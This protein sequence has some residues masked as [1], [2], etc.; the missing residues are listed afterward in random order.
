MVLQKFGDSLDTDVVET[1][2]RELIRDII[3]ERTVSFH[4]SQ[5]TD[6]MAKLENDYDNLLEGEYS[7]LLRFNKSGVADIVFTNSNPEH[8]WNL[9]KFDA[10]RMSLID[11]PSGKAG[12]MDVIVRMG[13][14]PSYYQYRADEQSPWWPKRNWFVFEI[15]LEGNRGDYRRTSSGHPD[16]SRIEWIEV[17]FVTNGA[18]TINMDK[19]I[20]VEK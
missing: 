8:L 19:L 12:L 14:G 6:G 4:L 11:N 17:R 13:D 2:V 10:I 9:N 15:P 20:F 16:M 18:T 7:L 1:D 3:E 5:S